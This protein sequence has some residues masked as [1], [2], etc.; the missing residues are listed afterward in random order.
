VRDAAHAPS[1]S[2]ALYASIGER[3]Q[4]QLNLTVD[5][6][7]GTV[8]VLAG[9]A[10][11]PK[12]EVNLRPDRLCMP[13]D[14]EWG[15]T[16]TSAALELLFQLEDGAEIGPVAYDV[17]SCVDLVRSYWSPFAQ[18]NRSQLL[19]VY[20]KEGALSRDE[21]ELSS[22]LVRARFDD[23]ARIA[24]LQPD[25]TG[26]LCVPQSGGN[27]IQGWQAVDLVRIGDAPSSLDRAFPVEHD[28]DASFPLGPVPLGGPP[29][30]SRMGRIELPLGTERVF[31]QF[32]LFDGTETEPA[33][34]P[35]VLLQ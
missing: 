5:L 34:L 6:P 14:R 17:S 7:K 3:T 32:V 25:R 31:A 8:R 24:W 12:R 13:W 28:L 33:E 4:E 35:I 22:I 18:R 1:S 23:A 10:G 9:L 19:R 16:P 11:R 26:V 2:P 15:A 29:S 21:H 30:G 27:A 20:R